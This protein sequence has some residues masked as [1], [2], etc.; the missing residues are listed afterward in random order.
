MIEAALW[1]GGSLMLAYPLAALHWLGYR[2]WRKATATVVRFE[3]D[4]NPLADQGSL[5]AP[6]LRFQTEGGEWLEVVDPVF[7][8][9]KLR[10][11]SKVAIVYPASA[12]SHARL[13]RGR[14]TM[15]IVAGTFGLLVFLVGLL[16]GN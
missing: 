11:G 9:A 16:G 5:K 3:N 12:A 4:P 10:V 1:T 7:T 14:Y 2:S 8:N 6:V 15:Q 13:A